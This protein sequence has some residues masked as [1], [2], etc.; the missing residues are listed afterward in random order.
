MNNYAKW[1]KYSKKLADKRLHKLM[2][3]KMTSRLKGS[4][5]GNKLPTLRISFLI[6]WQNKNFIKH[7]H[8]NIKFLSIK[9]KRYEMLLTSKLEEIFHINW[10]TVPVC[11]DPIRPLNMCVCV[12]N[13][14]WWVWFLS[15]GILGKWNKNILKQ[16][17]QIII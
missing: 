16:F 17:S 11:S 2:S 13:W 5:P 10:G 8:F 7:E 4:R 9:D 1:A 6:S 3:R 15:G 14:L 12:Y